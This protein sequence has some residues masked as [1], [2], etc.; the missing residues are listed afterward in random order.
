MEEDRSAELMA[1]AKDIFLK[2][3]A[4]IEEKDVDKMAICFY[5][6]VKRT[7]GLAKGQGVYEED[8]EKINDT[9]KGMLVLVKAMTKAGQWEEEMIEEFDDKVMK[10]WNVDGDDKC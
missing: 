9:L 3:V 2:M 8:K 4:I 5:D 1:S 7:Y 6:L 10:I